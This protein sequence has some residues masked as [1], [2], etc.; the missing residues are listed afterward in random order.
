MMIALNKNNNKSKELEAFFNNCIRILKKENFEMF[1]FTNYDF[2]VFLHNMG[3][4]DIDKIN[5]V[6]FEYNLTLKMYEL[7]I[8]GDG[9]HIIKYFKKLGGNLGK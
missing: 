5:V 7:G 1:K 2:Q 3:F 4:L 6:N 8:T 9:F